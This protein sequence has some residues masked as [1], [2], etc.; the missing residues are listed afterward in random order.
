MDTHDIGRP[1]AEQTFFDDPALDRVMAFVF[2]LSTEV[3]VLR[4]RLQRLEMALQAQG[5]GAAEALAAFAPSPEQA[6]ALSRDR[7][8]FTAS[9][10]ET[11][12]GKQ[13]SKGAP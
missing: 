6:A 4:D 7:E 13:V 8:A 9:L 3:W 12:L 2:T 10:M 5:G 11:L 1:R